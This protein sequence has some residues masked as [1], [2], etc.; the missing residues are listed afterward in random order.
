MKRP[1]VFEAAVAFL[2]EIEQMLAGWRGDF[3]PDYPGELPPP[4]ERGEK[5]GRISQLLTVLNSVEAAE[6][7]RA[8]A[9]EKNIRR[10]AA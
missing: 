8:I 2:E 6:L 4:T 5:E 3:E 10:K 7:K 9:R 1:D